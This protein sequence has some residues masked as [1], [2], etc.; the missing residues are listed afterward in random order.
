MDEKKVLRKR[1][2]GMILATD[3]A[4]HSSHINVIKY[5][6]ENKGI[7]KEAGNGFHMIDTKND[8]DKFQSQQ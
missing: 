8:H 4:D 1:V 2:I 3:M 5:K 6:V 7:S